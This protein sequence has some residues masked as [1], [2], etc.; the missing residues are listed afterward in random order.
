M[1]WLIPIDFDLP[2]CGS[3]ALINE[4]AIANVQP[5][6]FKHSSTSDTFSSF[7]VAF[8]IRLLLNFR[9]TRQNF[10]QLVNDVFGMRNVLVFGPV[11]NAF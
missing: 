8:A 1:N 10:F 7:L 11:R 9:V 4:D 3:F 5:H 2:Q 6:G